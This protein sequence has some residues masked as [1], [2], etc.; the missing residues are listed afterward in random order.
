MPFPGVALEGQ[1]EMAVSWEEGVML[2]CVLAIKSIGKY[3]K[4]PS[5]L[6]MKAYFSL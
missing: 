6:V 5:F 4:K 2:V 1:R 3:V